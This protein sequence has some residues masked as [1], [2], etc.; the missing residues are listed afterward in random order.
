MSNPKDYAN[1]PLPDGFTLAE[2]E[3]AEEP[4]VDALGREAIA[5][6]WIQGR[7]LRIT[8]RPDLSEKEFSVTLYHEILEGMTVGVPHP[9]ES[10]MDFNEGDFEREA[11]AAFERWG[12][13]SAENLNRIL[14]FFGFERKERR[15]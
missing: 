3:I 2:V 4:L 12:D 1:V 15:D 11:Y 14:Q 9:P 10:V 6:T 8:V 7:E 13:A 5:R